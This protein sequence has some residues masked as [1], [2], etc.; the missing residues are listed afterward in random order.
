VTID[1]DQNDAFKPAG[2]YGGVVKLTAVVM[3]EDTR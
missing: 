2:Y 3:P 1:W